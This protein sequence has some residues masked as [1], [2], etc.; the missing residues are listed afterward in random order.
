MSTARTP[1]LRLALPLTLLTL[2]ALAGCGGGMIGLRINM[3]GPGGATE[4][5]GVT[6][7]SSGV[8]MNVKDGTDV[9]ER[10]RIYYYRPT[11]APTEPARIPKD[12]TPLQTGSAIGK[13]DPNQ[14]QCRALAV[15][16]PGDYWVAVDY[17]I[18]SPTDPTISYYAAGRPSVTP[19]QVTGGIYPVHVVEKQTTEPTI[20]LAESRTPIPGQ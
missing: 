6:T 1:N 11:T 4:K 8:L 15:A 10:L 12:Q 18:A 9:C 2:S 7:L 13:Y 20:D 17:P 19:I 3:P 14:R 5:D 16:P